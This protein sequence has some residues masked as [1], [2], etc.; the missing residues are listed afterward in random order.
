LK[1]SD[2]L[3]QMLEPTTIAPSVN[4]NA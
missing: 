1:L 3:T 2:Y 4:A